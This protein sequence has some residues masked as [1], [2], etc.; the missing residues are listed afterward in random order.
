MLQH[1]ALLAVTLVL[2]ANQNVRADDPRPA[3]NGAVAN[4]IG[5]KLVPISAGEFLMGSPDSDKDAID[6]EKPQHKVKITKAFLMGQY[7]VTVGE[8]RQFI[9]DTGYKTVADKVGGIYRTIRPDG[10]IEVG[11]AGQNW[12]NIGFPITDNHPVCCVDFE[13][14]LEF[15]KWL[16]KKEGKTYRLPTEAEWEYACRAGT[17]T[18]WSCGDDKDA[19]VRHANIVYDTFPTFARNNGPKSESLGWM[20]MAPVG[21]FQANPWGLYDMHGNLWQWCSDW[22]AEDYYKHSPESNPTGPA[23]GDLRVIRGGTWSRGPLDCRSANRFGLSG[24]TSLW[25]GFR[26]ICEV[27]SSDAEAKEPSRE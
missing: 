17:T 23:E 20:F 12:E 4:T 11:K 19:L 18:R 10:K 1:S 16:S 8:F 13:D 27:R 9:K 6:D 15:C 7:H 22:Y 5:K 26:V 21:R 2:L 3:K 24:A 14:C 25:V